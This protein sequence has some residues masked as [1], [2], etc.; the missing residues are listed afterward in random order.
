MINSTYVAPI[1]MLVVS[2]MALGASIAGKVV[3]KKYNVA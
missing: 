2:I 1:A 3:S